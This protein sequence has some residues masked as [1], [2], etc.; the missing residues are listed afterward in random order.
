MRTVPAVYRDPSDQQTRRVTLRRPEPGPHTTRARAHRLL[1]RYEL[2]RRLGGGTAT[3]VHAATD[4]RLE[5]EVA[6]KLVRP[7]LARDG[8]VL[9]RLRRETLDLASVDSP[10][11]VGVHDLHLDGDE[12]FVVLQLVHGRALPDFMDEVRTLRHERAVRIAGELLDGLG[13]LHARG[14]IHQHV[15]PRDVMIDWNDRVVLLGVDPATATGVVDDGSD[16]GDVG[17]LLLYLLT[18]LQLPSGDTSRLPLLSSQVPQ[19]FGRVIR[20]A[21]AGEPSARFASAI[22]MKHALEQALQEYDEPRARARGKRL[23]Y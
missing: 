1:D 9:E 11:V 8:R 18:G 21:I 23:R 6:I 16:F 10:H 4:L 13:D 17:R 14:V 22:T 20:R 7:H 15:E 3:E 12:P 19:P 5:R 2:K